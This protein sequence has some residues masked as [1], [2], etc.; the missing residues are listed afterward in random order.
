[1]R[2]KNRT[3]IVLSLVLIVATGVL[4]RLRRSTRPA[5]QVV[6]Q[7]F[8]L[9]ITNT[10]ARATSRAQKV[11]M[12]NAQFALIATNPPLLSVTNPL[13]Y[14][15]SNTKQSFEQLL[16]NDHAVLLRNALIDTTIPGGLNIPPHLRSESDPGSYIVQARGAITEAFRARILA[17]GAEIV[18]YIPNN[19]Y[20]VRASASVAQ[21]LSREAQS[22]LPFEPYY[23]L[24]SRL[25]PLAVEQELSH[26]PLLNVV[27][28]PGQAEAVKNKL[29]QLGAETVGDAEPTPHGPVFA[30]K[31]PAESLAEVA[32]IP[33][34]QLLGVRFEKGTANDLTRVRVRIS[35]NTFTPPPLS[36]YRD[37]VSGNPLTGK[38]VM[39]AITDTGVD[40][41]HPDLKDRVTGDTA[42]D[43]TDFD[44]HGTHVAGTF[45]G[46]GT[47]SAGVGGPDA[48]NSWAR[49]ST[50]GANFSGM[51][52]RAK[53][54]VQSLFRPDSLL[55]R[56]TAVKGALISNNSWG[57]LGDHDYDI[58]AASYDAAVRDSAP[59][60][61]GEQEVMY[62][63]A[64]G[65]EGGGGDGGLSGLAGT[66][67]SPATA[68]NVITVG[69]SDLP[70]FITNEVVRCST[71]ITATSTNVICV[72]NRPWYGRTDTNN[73][74][75]SYSS[76]GNVGV[77]VEGVFGRIK[78]D[79]VA[80]GAMVVSTRSAQYVDPEGATNTF[81]LQYNGMTIGYRQT[82]L[83]ALII[84]ENA[85]ALTILALTNQFSPTN[86]TLVIGADI[87]RLPGVGSAF[88]VNRLD[89][90]L[91]SIPVALR[92]GTMFYSIANTNHPETI[93][94]D[95]VILVTLTN[96]VGNYY[97]VLKQLNAPLKQ[98]N[99]GYRYE[100][101]T[102]M[103]AP[104]VSGFLACVQEY[105]GTNFNIRP[106]PALL[107]AMVINGARSLSANYSLNNTAPINHQG[108]GL[109]N[110]S[111]TI[112][113]GLSI[114][115]SNGPLRFFD[116]SLTNS[117]ATG[118]TEVLS[119]YRAGRGPVL[120]VAHHSRL[121]RPAW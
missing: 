54:Y 40:V 78:P 62:V 33:E 63:F 111:N 74:V 81:M 8:Q 69:A 61:T 46:D 121:D 25:L 59:G 26:Y 97:T 115:P 10:P 34:V 43:I 110:M 16:R 116:Q 56:N 120:S 88:G 6:L 13:A 96:D 37:P 41:T 23:K 15:L 70:R 22:V 7:P 9:T 94:F 19:A 21:S 90:D 100:S 73:E 112:P 48:T 1:M 39:V 87:N 47:M 3:W 98:G 18:S 51:A 77:G 11:R 86:L 99:H 103:A 93:S 82:N 118:G 89:L 95:L 58:F 28:F 107:K 109:V 101:G 113:H 68:K 85:V 5:E 72:T 65:N 32:G 20:L 31:V 104:A 66:I 75:S 76:R 84:P 55:Q 36:H 79:V 83:H 71:Q 50:N 27:A 14:R 49:G 57:Y 64:S 108:W 52:P 117:L 4:W 106:S 105:L 53:A 67:V 17:S 80:P 44:G 45:F 29:Q 35:T 38:D 92:P 91:N 12:G 2:P 30:T 119:S 60:I 102:S 42:I 114:S 24:D